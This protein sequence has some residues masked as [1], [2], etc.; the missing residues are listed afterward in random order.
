[1]ESISEKAGASSSLK[2]RRRKPQGD[3]LDATSER[4]PPH[5]SE[6]EQ[7]VIGCILL[8]PKECLPQCQQAFSGSSPFYDLRHDA[9]YNACIN[10]GSEL[11]LIT[12]QQRL[13]DNGELDQI[14]GIAYLNALQDAVPSAANLAYYLNIVVEKYELRRLIQTCSGVIDRVYQYTGELPQLLDEVGHDIGRIC[15]AK[16][17]TGSVLGWDEM[18]NLDTSQDA[19]CILGYHNDRTTRYLCKGHSAWLIGPSGVG[20]SSLLFQ[21]GTCFATGKDFHGIATAYGR[22]MRILIVQAENDDGD[23]AEMAKGIHE[24]LAMAMEDDL[25]ELA[26][27]NIKVVSVTGKI[28]L[29]FCAWLRQ[30]IEAF[31]ADIVLVD[32]LLSFAGI[33]VSRQ[34]QVSQFCRVWLG[35]VLQETGVVMIAAH[36]TGK[37]PRQDGKKPQAQ[38]LTDLAYA[39]IGSSEL[40]NWARAV[41]LLQTAGDNLYRLILAKRGKRACATNP[42]GS[43]TTSIWLRHAEGR[44]FWEHCDPPAESESKGKN[45]EGR[46]SKVEDLIA[47]GLGS[48]IDQ[49][50]TEVGKLELSRRIEKYA[51]TKSKDVSLDTCK[52]AVEKLVENGAIKK[53]D[54]GYIKP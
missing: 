37:P 54:N 29:Q 30:E 25:L 49:L 50:S 23:M 34:D 24:G 18:M 48:V 16:P 19:N 42:D 10:L 43:R 46:P 27:R 44:I 28:G 32:P 45:K 26:R 39:G 12:L 11:D 3:V 7:G 38:S 2:K 40:V 8:S 4:L 31:R 33:D 52:R 14:G 53:T 47:I 9:I 41:M 51:A 1:M 6:S 13:K 20:K 22:P 15:R 36:H 35:P 5:S 17:V 21:M